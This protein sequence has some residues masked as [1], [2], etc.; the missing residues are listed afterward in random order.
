MVR[1]VAL[2]SAGVRNECFRYV[3]VNVV[4]GRVV[5]CCWFMYEFIMMDEV[6]FKLPP[7]KFCGYGNPTYPRLPLPTLNI[8][9]FIF[10]YFAYSQQIQ[11]KNSQPI[12][13]QIKSTNIGKS[14]L[15]VLVRNVF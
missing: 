12:R 14:L 9:H 5:V 1:V 15:N 6:Y 8:L 2:Q 7:P 10:A 11:R 13:S 4:E 3:E